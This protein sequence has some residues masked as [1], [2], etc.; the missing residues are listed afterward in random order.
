MF[1]KELRKLTSKFKQSDTTEK[2]ELSTEDAARLRLSDQLEY[3]HQQRPTL[4]HKYKETLWQLT[5]AHLELEEGM[6]QTITLQPLR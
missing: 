3:L 5:E 4:E 2:D 1:R 6:G